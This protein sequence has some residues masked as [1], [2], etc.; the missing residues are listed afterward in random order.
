[1]ANVGVLAGIVFLA[2]EIQQN[3]ESLDE[4][5]NLAF[6]E[7][8]QERRTQ[9]D[10]SFRSLANSQYM[11]EIFATYEEVGKAGLSDEQLQRF[12]WQSCSGMFR[13]DTFHAWYER[14]YVAP[15]DY[16]VEFENVVLYFAPR[17]RDL[18]IWP[19]RP[20]FRR[21]VE[22]VLVDAGQPLLDEPTTPC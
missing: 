11:P 15:E 22:R 3:T 18:G 7:A 4:S 21:A 2:I 13:L 17:W 14:G 12:I 8:Q 5:R 6:A 9:L 16:A 1:M 19:L 10:E 20:A